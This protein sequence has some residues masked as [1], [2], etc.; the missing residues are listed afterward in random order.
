[1]YD[2]GH[3]ETQTGRGYYV[4]RESGQNRQ[5]VIRHLF[6]YTLLYLSLDNACLGIANTSFASCRC[7][8]N[9]SMNE[10]IVNERIDK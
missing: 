8:M 9:E 2:R 7:T 3:P 1:M 5:H 4:I 10:R 6:A